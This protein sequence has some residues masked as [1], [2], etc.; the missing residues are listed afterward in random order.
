MFLLL[1]SSWL[2]LFCFLFPDGSFGKKSACSAGDP[3]LIPGLGRS[4]GEGKGCPLQYSGLEK[5]ID[6][7][8]RGVTKSWTRLSDFL[9]HFVALDRASSAVLTAS[10]GNRHLGR[11]LMVEEHAVLHRLTR[12][13]MMTCRWSW[14]N[15]GAPCFPSFFQSS[16][17]W[18]GVELCQ[19]LFL[20]L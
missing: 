3:G 11:F 7:I 19:M 2:L 12:R 5:S 17:S 9:F 10:G 20:H 15:C 1:Q 4:P 16:S 14:L 8:A 13:E 18:M 6:S